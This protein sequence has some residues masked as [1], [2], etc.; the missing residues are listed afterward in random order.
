MSAPRTSFTAREPVDLIAV[1]PFLL[2][3]HPEQ[4]VVLLTFGTDTFHARVDLPTDE[5]DQ[6]VVV[7]ML[8]EVLGRH[9][10]RRAALLLY[11]EDPWTAATFH[12]VAVARLVGAGVE[13]V[14]VLRVGPERFHDAGD[15]D[16]PGT[17]YDV[18]AHAFTA[19]QVLEGTVVHHNRAELAATLETV[20]R[21]E[22]QEVAA[23]VDR[24]A[25][26]LFPTG[27]V[28]V[29]FAEQ[30]RW[31]QLVVRTHVGAG[32]TPTVAEAARLLLLVALVDVRDVAWAEM[33]RADAARHVELWRDL[34]RRSPRDLVPAAASL[35][36]FA[37]WLDGR[38]ALAWCALDRCVAVD[39][40]YSMADC[41]SGLLA[42]A[43]P[44]S[45]WTPIAEADLPVFSGD[46]R[47]AS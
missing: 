1:V 35:L 30:A 17:A 31:V 7:E 19:E 24:F 15:V 42:G 10:V 29:D 38:G 33:T 26:E 8:G 2:G 46:D 12:D 3:F 45:V 6:V 40:E 27:A 5:D 14:D 18:K 44:P 25:G 9:Q 4:S 16:D 11:T 43:A 32:T 28:D 34:L 39:P 37:A 47:W 21:L 20:D 41:I 23:E 13:L 22:A 36:A